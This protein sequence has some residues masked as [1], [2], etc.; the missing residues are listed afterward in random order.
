MKSLNSFN[1]QSELTVA[2][3]TFAIFRL[4]AG[5]KNDDVRCLAFTD[6]VVTRRI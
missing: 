4:A 5:I 6:W 2:G 1:A 3:E